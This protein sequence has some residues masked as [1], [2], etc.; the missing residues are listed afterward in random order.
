[1]RHRQPAA[2]GPPM[3]MPTPYDQGQPPGPHTTPPTALRTPLARRRKSRC[4]QAGNDGVPTASVA[5]TADC[6]KDV[7]CGSRNNEPMPRVGSD[8]YSPNK[9]PP[10]LN[11]QTRIAAETYP[12]APAAPRRSPEPRRS[13]RRRSQGPTRSGCMPASPSTPRVIATND[14]Q[15]FVSL[16]ECRDVLVQER[17]CGRRPKRRAI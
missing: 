15:A 16:P 2:R 7:E 17:R 10:K 4:R 1:M 12:R 13:S 9:N 11:T 3:T 5:M 14:P 8:Q 6:M